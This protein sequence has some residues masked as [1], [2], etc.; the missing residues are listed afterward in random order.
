[1]GDTKTPNFPRRLHQYTIGAELGRGSFAAVYKAFNSKN[2]RSYAI[3]ILPKN[4]LMSPG[5]IQRFQ[6]EVNAS[7]FLI[8]DNIVA[9]HDFFW[10][11]N[12]FYLIQDLCSGGDL[13]HYITK[14]DHLSE[15]VSAFLF[16]QI[17]RAIE[18]C[19]SFNVAHRDLKPENILIEKFP[20]VRVTDFGLCGYIED[21]IKMTTFCGSTAYCA[22]ECL[23][24]IEYDGRMADIWSLGVILYVMVTGD[25]PWD[26]NTGKMIQQIKNADYNLPTN[27]SDDCRDLISKMIRINPKERIT[28]KEVLEHPFMSLAASS[29]LKLPI[30]KPDKNASAKLPPL[31][32]FSLEEIGK[33][34]KLESTITEERFGIVSPFEGNCEENG[35]DDED[36]YDKN[37]NMPPLPSFAIRCQSFENFFTTPSGRKKVMIPKGQAR[38]SFMMQRTKHRRVVNL[39]Q[40]LPPMV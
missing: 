3:K 28:I 1:M 38:Q 36:E 40:T 22:P 17:C 24:K 30:K 5:D 29:G 34:V 4:N 37:K 14:K 6:R 15:E 10:D 32:G 16:D 35:E 2:R 21:D 8:H 33:A 12:N 26:N 9:V 13:F 20:L 39:N 23:S 18:Y 31:D 27:L 25:S 19:H 7:S 11:D